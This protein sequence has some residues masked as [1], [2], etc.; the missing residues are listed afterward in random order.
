MLLAFFSPDHGNLHTSL[1]PKIVG[2]NFIAIYTK[3]FVGGQNS[4]NCIFFLVIAS[5]LNLRFT[6]NRNISLL[7]YVEFSL[8]SYI[9]SLP[10]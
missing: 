1:L 2:G 8:F 5:R 7:L 4:V 3:L 6:L 10:K 9:M